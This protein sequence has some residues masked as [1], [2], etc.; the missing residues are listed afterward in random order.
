MSFIY[1]F[2]ATQWEKAPNQ[3]LFLSDPLLVT[4]REFVIH[5]Q[6]LVLASIRRTKFYVLCIVRDIR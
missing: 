4:S 1:L 5:C 6:E 2:N 3:A